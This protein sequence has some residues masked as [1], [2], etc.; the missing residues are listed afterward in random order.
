MR[1]IYR[2]GIQLDNQSCKEISM[3]KKL[4]LILISVPLITRMNCLRILEPHLLAVCCKC[5]WE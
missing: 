5:S 1:M 4:F 2:R 3:K